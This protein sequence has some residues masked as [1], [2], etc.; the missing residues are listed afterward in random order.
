MWNLVRERVAPSAPLAPGG[1][2]D[3][4]WWRQQPGGQGYRSWRL[5]ICH[6]LPGHSSHSM[7]WSGTCE[8]C[9]GILMDSGDF[10][11]IS[12]V[13][14]FGVNTG[15][16]GAVELWFVQGLWIR[17]LGR[18]EWRSL[19]RRWITTRTSKFQGDVL[20]NPPL[21][22]RVA[23]WFDSST[24]F[25]PPFLAGIPLPCF[26]GQLL[27]EGRD[28][29]GRGRGKWLGMERNGSTVPENQRFY[30][31]FCNLFQ[32]EPASISYHQL[33]CIEERRKLMEIGDVFHQH[34]GIWATG[35]VSW[36]YAW[37]FPKCDH[38]AVGT[39]TVIDKKGIQRPLWVQWVQWVRRKM[40]VIQ[41]F[42]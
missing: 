19:S 7:V 17:S 18:S 41:W 34:H 31:S 3:W 25:K 29:R 15:S 2:C 22:I 28:V 33:R 16:T 4:G 9:L 10:Q 23:R 27:G 5:R 12:G 24:I 6:R 26:A 20:G 39:G 11:E 30:N 8:T 35:C 42:Q 1:C 13:W 36:L 37:V 32:Q 40:I 38:V 21:W 14:D